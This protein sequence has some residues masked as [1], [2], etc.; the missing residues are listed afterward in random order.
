MRKTF[1]T[2]LSLCLILVL[3]TTSY[4]ASSKQSLEKNAN[5]IYSSSL[6]K[7]FL[8]ISRDQMKKEYNYNSGY[9]PVKDLFRDYVD[10]IT[11]DGKKKIV[12][13]KNQG[14][15]L[16]LNA[17]GGMIRSADNQVVAP[18]E[19]IR[20]SNG[21]IQIKSSVVAYIF[22]REGDAYKDSEREEWKDKLSFLNIK[23]TVGLPD[24]KSDG[25][26]VNV[27]YNNK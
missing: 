9:I 14:S 26:F 18:S 19:W 4:A 25:L 17:S 27:V 5:K 16:I 20:L 3:S 10:S 23:E 6:K 12:V 1:V 8:V 7:T 2:M 15:E 22:D 24:V 13:I 11:W 21:S